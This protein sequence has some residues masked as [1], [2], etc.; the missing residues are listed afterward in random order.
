[1]YIG[2]F[3]MPYCEV[4]GDV[5]LYYED[6]GDGPPIVFTNAGNLTHKIWMGQ[7]ASLAAE[8]R[9]ITYDIRGTGLSARP[10][11]GYSAEVAA[12]DLCTLVECLELPPAT[13]VA[14]GIGTHIALLAA[15]MRPDLVNALALVS[16]G[17]WFHGARNGVTAGV[18]DDFIAFLTERAA[19]GVP[20]AQICA[21]MIDAWLFRT[22]PSAGVVH[23]LLEQ[24]LAW[25]QFVLKALSQSMRDI[26][27]RRRLPG[28]ACPVLVVH[29]RHDRK[30]LYA[31]AAQVAQL[32]P[33]GRLVTLE[34]SAHMGQL[35]ELNTF[36]RMLADFVRAVGSTGTRR[37]SATG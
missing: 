9:T 23:A 5:A 32:A 30:Q 36:N 12:A 22:P 26:D 24:A 31:G 1:M 2:K 35:E 11:V 4:G 6:F 10:R 37:Q 8:F 17:P 34:H 19:Q 21:E 20:Y 29:G 14:H 18:A 3:P 13:M 15:D 25:P 27:H 16:G 7:V 33:A 28:L